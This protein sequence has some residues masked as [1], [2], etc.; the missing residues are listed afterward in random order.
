MGAKVTHYVTKDSGQREQYETGA[1]RDVRGGKGRYDL[2]ST[3]A[4][5]RRAGVM[6]RGAAKYDDRNWEKGIN[7][8]RCLD[9][10]LRHI[11]QYIEGMDDE[12]HLAQAGVNLDFAL[13]F[14]EGIK[15]GVYPASLDDRPRYEAPGQTLQEAVE[16]ALSEAGIH[17]EQEPAPD[18]A[19]KDMAAH[20]EEAMHL[21]VR[22]GAHG[23]EIGRHNH[24]WTVEPQWIDEL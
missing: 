19:G 9:S 12:D 6:E 21:D 15:R 24:P 2:I 14:D 13:H 11:A 18:V 23:A 1:M 17:Y 3:F 7:I 20:E 8:M 22:Y 4:T 10:A 5:R 16:Q